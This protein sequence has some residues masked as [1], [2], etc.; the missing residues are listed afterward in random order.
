MTLLFYDG[1]DVG[2]VL[3]KY[4]LAVPANAPTSGTSTRYGSGRSIVLAGTGAN[5]QISRKIPAAAQVFV[6]FAFAHSV[7]VTGARFLFLAGDNGATIHLQL[8]W[9]STGVLGLYRGAT[10][11]AT[12]TAISDPVVGSG[13]WHYLEMSATIDDTTG[14]VIL[15]CDGVQIL[16]FT[17]DTKNGGSNSTIDEVFLCTYVGSG[18]ITY[19]DDVYILDS[20]GSAPYNTFLGE[21]RIY[22]TL[23][24][25]AGATTQWTPSAGT[26]FG[27]VD[28][29]PYSASDYVSTSTSGNRDTYAMSDLPSGVGTIYAVR[30][31]AAAKKSDAGAASL[32]VVDRSGGANYYGTTTALATGDVSVFGAIRTVDPATSAAW[33]ASGVN[34]LEAG[35][36]LA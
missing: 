10:L 20:G 33:T 27:A 28:D 21:V 13:F 32:K 23:P 9:I 7:V 14:S 4:N 15:R 25:G 22:T 16:S 1:A 34:A 2:D 5:C 11:L 24:T 26:N 35:I 30:T 17:G 36:E 3:V 6:G 8:Q 29:V 31:V 18:G 19:F 12:A